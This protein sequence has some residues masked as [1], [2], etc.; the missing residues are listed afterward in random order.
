M[1]MFWH[2]HTADHDQ[3]VA[4]AGLVQDL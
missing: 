2:Q 4:L 3:T 1:N